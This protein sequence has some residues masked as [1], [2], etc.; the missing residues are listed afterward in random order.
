MNM[1][2]NQLIVEA[3][4]ILYIVKIILYIFLVFICAFFASI[5]TSLLKYTGNK[6]KIKNNLLSYITL[7]EDKPEDILST[8]L[9]GTNLACI[10]VGVIS[11]SIGLWIGFSIIILLVL[12]EI[13]PKVFAL[14]YPQLVL[15][16]GFKKLILFSKIVSP[17]A[18]FFAGI[19]IYFTKIFLGI[20]Q[21]NPF[22]TKRELKKIISDE[23]IDVDEK[24]IYSNIIELADKKVYNVMI[25]K[26][27][28]VAVDASWSFEGIIEKLSN[29]KFSRVPVYKE[30]IDN[31]IGIV[32]TKDLIIAMQNKEIFV[33]EDLLRKP[34]FV[35]STTKVIDLLRK[36]KEGQYHMAIVVDEY[37]ATVGLVT[38]EDIIEEL[39]GEIYDEYDVREQKIYLLDKNTAVLSGDENIKEVDEKLNLNF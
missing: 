38:I 23:V 39:V 22:L 28:I 14:L 3:D 5:E 11:N 16:L 30:N 15:N 26:E 35:V 7:W 25:P 27:D 8:I 34:F 9:I 32:Y 33:L 13:F 37:G 36:F 6:F 1:I 24:F 18:K 29:T 19:S 2:L 4:K 12:G 31:I 10:G 17:F 20:E 21:E